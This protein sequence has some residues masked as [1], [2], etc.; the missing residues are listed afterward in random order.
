MLSL[1]K[2]F[3]LYLNLYKFD[4]ESDLR[5]IVYDTIQKELKHQLQDPVLYYVDMEGKYTESELAKMPWVNTRINYADAI[6]DAIESNGRSHFLSTSDGREV[7]V[8]DMF[9]YRLKENKS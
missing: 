9:L 8:G 4:N 1:A 3:G 5:K 6:N 7:H 2:S